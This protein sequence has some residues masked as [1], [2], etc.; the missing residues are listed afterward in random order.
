MGQSVAVL[1]S[2]VDV[3]HPALRDSL[4]QNVSELSNG[5]DDDGNG[6]VDDILGWNFADNHSEL[7]DPSLRSSWPERAYQY[8]WIRMKRSFGTWSASEE[9][10]YQESRAD[11]E[12]MEIRS[13]FSSY[14][15]GT[16]VAAIALNGALK[17]PSTDLD[18]PIPT[19]Y[20]VKS[21]E[22]D[23][24]RLLPIRYLG[25]YD[26]FPW[27]RPTP[28]G[29][30]PSESLKDREAAYR[31]FYESY[32]AWQIGK[33]VQALKYAVSFDDVRVINGSF[34]ISLGSTSDMFEDFL[35]VFH[36][37]SYQG[38]S[39]RELAAKFIGELNQEVR[40]FAATTP[41]VLYT[42]SAGNS[43]E[44][45]DQN[46]H[47]PSGATSE[48]IMSVGASLAFS[49]RAYFSNYGA[50]SVD[51]FAPG[52]AILSSVSPATEIPINGTSQAAP[53]IA[54]LAL[55]LFA[56]NKSAS[57]SEVKAIMMGTVD[58]QR[59]LEGFAL[60]AGIVNPARAIQGMKLY[61]YGMTLGD[62]LLKARQQVPDAKT[63]GISLIKKWTIKTNP[64]DP[65][66]SPIAR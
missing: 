1:D 30:S 62:A 55:K 10:W 40:A 29:V 4:H 39:P 26:Y 18:L 65:L 17:I 49:E 42:F 44:N 50:K 35:A 36:L 23:S 66:P 46:P 11:H 2:G 41:R 52:L 21:V 6:L 57:A 12:F 7:L 43:E 60:S 16:H 48:N 32:F 24:F 20:Q 47:F 61:Q 51:L 34:G 38:Q 64:I 5:R 63:A 31:E 45:T 25:D 9:A 56:L 58:E 27:R 53:F 8:Y 15:H 22:S 59:E 14:V 33:L 3:F 28:R 37:E 19:P 13:D 54:H